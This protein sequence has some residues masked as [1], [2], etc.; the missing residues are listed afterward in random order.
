MSVICTPTILILLVIYPK[1]SLT[2]G[3][4]FY[5]SPH[6]FPFPALRGP[7]P[8]CREGLSIFNILSLLFM[9]A[10]YSLLLS[11]LPAFTRQQVFRQAENSFWHPLPKTK[12][13]P[14]VN[15]R[16]G[17]KPAGLIDTSCTPQYSSRGALACMQARLQHQRTV[18]FESE[19]VF[20][21]LSKIL[22]IYL[23]CLKWCRPFR[24]SRVIP[25]RCALITCRQYPAL[26][27]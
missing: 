13:R 5:C 25:T 24:Y 12:D 16:R 27:V 4:L 14:V 2:G 19:L 10:I 17:Y 26:L 21:F 1:S 7:S 20:Y 9:V 8:R 15:S 11:H 22:W 3:R 18:R 23:P 6:L